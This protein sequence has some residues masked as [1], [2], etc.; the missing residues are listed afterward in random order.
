MRAGYDL[1]KFRLALLD[2]M[3]FGAADD[4]LAENMEKIT[5]EYTAQSGE[6]FKSDYDLATM[7]CFV[8]YKA[9]LMEF[10]LSGSIDE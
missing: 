6:V 9:L 2:G 10:A 5:D 8:K 4:Y 3:P 7:K 1:A